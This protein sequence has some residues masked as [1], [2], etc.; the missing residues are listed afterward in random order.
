MRFQ[1]LIPTYNRCTDLSRNLDH[2]R[3]QLLKYK[4]ASVFEIVVSDNASS[5]DSLLM[6]EQKRET[7]K[8]EVSLKFLTSA[9]NAGLEPN[10]LKL[11][12]YATADYIIWLGDD[13]F[14]AEGYLAFINEEFSNAELGWMIPGL[15]ETDQ[16]GKRTKGRSSDFSFRRFPSGYKTVYELSHFAHQ[17][18]GLVVR[19]EGLIEAYMAKP[20]WRNPYLFIFFTAYCQLHNPGIYAPGYSSLINNY[21]PKDWGYNRIGLL[22]EV[23]K[24]YYYLRDSIGRSNLNKL[25]LRFTLMHSYRIDFTKGIGNVVRQGREILRAVDIPAGLHIPLYKL[26]IKEY[27]AKKIRQ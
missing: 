7:W 27:L 16:T 1:I 24:S 19:R 15:E 9:T 26:L 21:N 5:D 12:Q 6:L 17:M 25:L 8:G 10:V 20:N 18:S 23:F 4:I 22:D 3:D 2:L 11:L 14:L 13:D